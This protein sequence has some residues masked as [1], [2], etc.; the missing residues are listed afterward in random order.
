MATVQRLWLLTVPLVVILPVLGPPFPG[1]L[2]G[3]VGGSVHAGLVHLVGA[4][5]AK[6]PAALT[7]AKSGQARPG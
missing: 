4:V 6:V 2:Q 5:G 1:R 7:P 3:R